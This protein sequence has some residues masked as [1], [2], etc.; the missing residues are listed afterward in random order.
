[1]SGGGR[2]WSGS[3]ERG[4]TVVIFAALIVVLALAGVAA[5]IR[6]AARDIVKAIQL[7]RV[8]R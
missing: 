2:F 7:E 4:G 5:D 8:G 1:M 3:C 6:G